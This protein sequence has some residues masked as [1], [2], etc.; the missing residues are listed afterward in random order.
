MSKNFGQTKKITPSEN[1]N[2]QSAE[3]ALEDLG[4]VKEGVYEAENPVSKKWIK[5]AV[6]RDKS[7]RLWA[8]YGMDNYNTTI[9]SITL[10]RFFG[11]KKDLN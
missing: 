11:T 8:F 6:F 9:Y 1:K 5:R 3:C 10:K 7:N 2:Y 4:Y